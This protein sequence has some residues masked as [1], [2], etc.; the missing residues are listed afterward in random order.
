MSW[1]SLIP[2]GASILGGIFGGQNKQTTEQQ[3]SPELEAAA[4]AILERAMGTFS[5]PYPEYTGQRVAQPTGSRAALDAFLPSIGRSVGQSNSAASR[6]GAKIDKMMG[7]T[8][9]RIS[10]PT[11]TGNT[12]IPTTT[13]GQVGYS[14]PGGAGGY[15]AAA[16]AMLD[17][18]M[19][20]FDPSRVAYKPGAV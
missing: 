20:G 7:T 9:T 2:L 19:A 6:Y 1:T 8:P 11:L 15:D 4:Q 17:K 14:G 3:N 13:G 5:K 16:G 10:V 18:A 12:V